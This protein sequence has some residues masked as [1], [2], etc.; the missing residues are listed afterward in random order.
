MRDPVVVMFVPDDFELHPQ[1]TA[2]SVL[3]AQVIIPRGAPPPT[4]EEIAAAWASPTR[5]FAR[6]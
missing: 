4:E 3:V 5:S 6:E 1:N 2:V